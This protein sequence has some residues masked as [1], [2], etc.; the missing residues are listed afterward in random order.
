M[1]IFIIGITGLLGSEAARQFL[2]AGHEVSGLTLAD[3]PKDLDLPASVKLHVGSY[4]ELSEAEL[5]KLLKG[6]DG[7]VFAAGID[8]RIKTPPPA[9]LTFNKYNV[10]PLKDILRIAKRVGIKHTVILGSYFTY[11]NRTKPQLNLAKTHPY[12]ES[13]MLQQEVAFTFSDKNFDVAVLELPYIF[14]VQQ[15]RAPVWTFLVE[16]LLAMKGATYYPRGG[17][18]MVTVRQVGEAIVG[19]LLTNKGAN[20][21]PI[22]YYNVTWDA[23]LSAMHRALGEPKRRIIHVPRF[24]YKIVMRRIYKKDLKAGYEGGLNLGK[25]SVMHASNQFMPI[26]PSIKLGVRADDIF[27]AIYDS[28]KLSY[29]IIKNKEQTVTMTLSDK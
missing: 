7:L 10:Q 12:I 19:A 15:G 2:K 14:G 17:S 13:R 3:Y 22:N 6:C 5:T 1:K 16:M 4:L 8:E 26:E 27:A 20:A 11:F 29:D 21:Y 28:A 9:L 18:A 25:F 23:M 24:I